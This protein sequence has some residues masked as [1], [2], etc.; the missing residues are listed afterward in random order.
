[1]DL[2]EAICHCF[3]RLVAVGL[4]K[5]PKKLQIKM[6]FLYAALLVNEFSIHRILS[7][8]FINP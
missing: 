5:K 3:R 1:M 8:V 4:I 2:F 7:F 6:Y